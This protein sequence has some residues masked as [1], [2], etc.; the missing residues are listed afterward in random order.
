MSGVVLM[1]TSTSPSVAEV[2]IAM[3]RYLFKNALR[4]VLTID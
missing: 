1:S 3:G 4:T 2:D